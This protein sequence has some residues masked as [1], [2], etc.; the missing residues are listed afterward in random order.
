[1][2]LLLQ[3]WLRGLVCTV[4]RL[5]LR[6]LQ[7]GL[8]RGEAGKERLDACGCHCRLLLGRRC[9]MWRAATQLPGARACK[10]CH[11]RWRHCSAALHSGTAGAGVARQQHRQQLLPIQVC[12]WPLCL[13]LCLRL[14]RACRLL[15]KREDGWQAGLGGTGA[16]LGR[17][18]RCRQAGSCVLALGG[19]ASRGR[20][21]RGTLGAHCSWHRQGR[22][23]R[24]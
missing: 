17:R 14:L 10:R 19:G 22:I 7:D 2:L 3:G 16:R 13:C 21:G 15:Q 5:L 9:S 8:A 6:L 18:R 20:G 1:M 12:R 23:L 11:R 4:C 24:G